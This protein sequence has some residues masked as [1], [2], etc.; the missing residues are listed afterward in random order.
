MLSINKNQKILNNIK[1]RLLL[2]AIPGCRSKNYSRHLEI[3]EKHKHSHK[4]EYK[5]KTVLFVFAGRKDRMS[6]LMIYLKDL[7][8]KKLVDYIHIW[9]F[10]RNKDDFKWVKNLQDTQSQIV[11][12]TPDIFSDLPEHPQTLYREAYQ[13]YSDPFFYNSLFIKCDD[14]IVYIDTSEQS[15][16]R[17]LKKIKRINSAAP[18]YAVSANVINNSICAYFQ[19]NHKNLLPDNIFFFPF[20]ADQGQRGKAMESYWEGGKKSQILHEYFINHKEKFISESQ[21]RGNVMVDIGV[22]FSINFIGF[23]PAIF[24]FFLKNKFFL[25]DEY[26]F[27]IRISKQL[28]KQIMIY[29]PLTVSHLSYFSQPLQNDTLLIEKY[30]NL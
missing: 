2:F 22:R 6:L 13:F 16:N 19:Q 10:A 14:D 25:D 18:Y 7:L 29:M 28:R 20:P 9:N 27:S 8:T 23:K 26:Y 11:V 30:Y 17:F 15:F 21:K 3:F 5:D 12:F 24:S 4:R 1:T